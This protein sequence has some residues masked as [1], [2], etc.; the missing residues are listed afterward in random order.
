MVLQLQ[1]LMHT[2]HVKLFA[3]VNYYHYDL[4]LFLDLP[5][6]IPHQYRSAFQD[7]PLP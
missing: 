7:K 4:L 6:D 3:K 5:G 1:K 2:Y